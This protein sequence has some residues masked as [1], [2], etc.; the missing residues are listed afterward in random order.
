MILILFCSLSNYASH[1]VGGEMIYDYLGNSKYRIT[2]KIYRDCSSQTT[3]DGITSPSGNLAPANISVLEVNS[4]AIVTGAV[5]DIGA[6][7]VTQ[8]PPTINSPCIQTPNNI[9]V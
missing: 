5:I 6:P 8:I 9:C 2:L 4:G 7:V 1:I 3:F